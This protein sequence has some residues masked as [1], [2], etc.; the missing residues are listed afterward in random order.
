[1]DFTLIETLRWEPGQ[2]FIRLDQ[3]LRRLSRSADALGFRQPIKPEAALKEVVHGDTPLRVRLAMNF[4]GKLEAAAV[5]FES[6]G[7][8]TIW[9]LRIA[10]KTR[11]NSE[12]T[13]YRHKTSR[14]DPYD[15]A[16][17]E[18]STEEADEVLLLNERGEI[19]EG[20]FTNVFVQGLDGMLTTPPLTSGLIPGILR[21]E[22]IRDRK[23]RA[24]LLKPESLNGRAIFVGNSLRGLIR[25]ELVEEQHRAVA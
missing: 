9:R 22:L 2:G 7:E 8:N 4:R 14:R 18:F 10:Q 15:A 24:N 16:R 3:H 25:A 19:C 13:L 12:D 17:A 21:A 20:T 23:A 11:L 5:P 1:M 6:V